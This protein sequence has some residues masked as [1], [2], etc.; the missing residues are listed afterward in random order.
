MFS[1][2]I[3]AKNSLKYIDELSLSVHWYSEETCE[4]QVGLKYHYR[5]FQRIVQNIEK[6]KKE[7]FFFLNIVINRYNYLDVENIIKFVI[8][9]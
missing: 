2:Q 4:K 7:N 5:N 6:Y 8:E 3:F 1:S 9:S